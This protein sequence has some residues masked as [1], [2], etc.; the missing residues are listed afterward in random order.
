ML[1]LLLITIITLVTSTLSLEIPQH[2]TINGSQRL[3]INGSRIFDDEGREFVPR[4]FNF[5]AISVKVHTDEGKYMR[6]L[7]NWSNLAR[8]VGIPW[9]N[10]PFESQPSKRDCMT[11]TYPYIKES[12][13]ED[14]DVTVR[15]SI[16]DD[17]VWAILSLR[18]E[19]IAGQNF[20]TNPNE[21]VFHN[22]TLRNM[23]YD[24]WKYV[25]NRYKTFDRIAAY[26]VLSEPR[27]KNVAQSIVTEFY[28]G[29]CEAVRNSES[30]TP[31][32]IG[33]R[34]YYNIFEFE[35]GDDL[36]LSENSNVIYTF[37]FFMPQ[38]WFEYDGNVQ[39]YP[40]TYKCKDIYKGYVNNM[41]CPK[42]ADSMI[43]FD[44]EWLKSVL[45]NYVVTFRDTHN[46]P[47]FLN[48]FAVHYQVSELNGR[49]E[50][51]RDLISVR[52]VRAR[53]SILSI[54]NTRTPMLEHRYFT[55]WTLDTRGG[56]F[57]VPAMDIADRT[58]VGVTHPLM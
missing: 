55:S 54:Y 47:I 37:D 50:Y 52:S 6:K 26:E 36:V 24:M 8:I 23:M 20:E 32:M 3:S 58:M 21:N 27:D 49:Y 56:R 34:P 11:Y 38:K 43:S 48:Q 57:E 45:E 14:L 16:S 22:E 7:S 4:G 39:T 28:R 33:P 25:S 1:Q 30:S 44:R 15:N 19:Y 5:N 41:N 10:V 46:V 42:G 51:V 9:G 13:L 35:N 31:C 2:V 29:A 53:T 17:N 40:G 18:G 12:C